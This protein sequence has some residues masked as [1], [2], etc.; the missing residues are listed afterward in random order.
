MKMTSKGQTVFDNNIIFHNKK[1]INKKNELL[2]LIE[3][4]KKLLG[5]FSFSCQKG[6]YTYLGRDILGTKKLFFTVYKKKIYSS[7]NFVDLLKKKKF[8]NDNIFSCPKGKVLKFEEDRLVKVFDISPKEIFYRKK[9]NNL[10]IVDQK[11][12]F[13][14]R[15]LKKK[16]SKVV[17]ALS[18]GLDS[19]IILDKAKK[20]FQSNTYA[21]TCSLQK[22]KASKLTED[23][24]HAENISKELK[25]QHIKILFDE[26]FVIKNLNK[27]LY[28]S[29]DWRDY[30]VHCAVINYVLAQNIKK[31]FNLKK[32]VLITGDFMNEYFA[33]YEE[34]KF[35]G[36]TYYKQLR[37]NQKIRQ[38]FFIKGLDSSAREVGVFEYFG[39]QNFQPYFIVKS[40]YESLKEKELNFKNAKYNYNKLL[41]N[42]KLFKLINS[43]KIR[44][45]SDPFNGGIIG[46]F[47]SNGI[48]SKDLINK[49]K[50]IFLV[51]DKFIKNFINVGSYKSFDKE[52]NIKIK[53]VV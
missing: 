37:T 34:E 36:K 52:S 25:V 5:Q 19:T 13:L 26:K 11:L 2:L 24:I 12:N 1:K 16:Y 41:I 38:R 4:R 31:K 47:H 39:I 8:L 35:E 43:K 29:Q 17:V 46:I 51:N 44:A 3:N 48:S 15:E 42:K 10:K 22:N 50:N 21:A 45:Q 20:Y 33:D 49:F 9:K 30:N 6:K 7:K 32:T 27:I 18:G 40:N 28:T 14:F 23:M 53:C